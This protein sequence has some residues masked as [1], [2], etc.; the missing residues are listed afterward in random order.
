[1]V[2]SLF[3]S[4]FVTGSVVAAVVA[5]CMLLCG[6]AVATAAGTSTAPTVTVGQG[7]NAAK[8]PGAQVFGDTP[9]STPESV[10]FI[11]REQNLGQLEASV[12]QGFGPYLSVAQFARTYGQTSENVA[13][14]EAYLSQFGIKTQ[15]YRDNVDVVATGTAGEFDRALGVTQHQYRVP[16]LPGAGGAPA[17][18]AQT[19]HGAAQAPKLPPSIAHYVLAVLGLS[20][21]APFVSHIAH[22]DTK[23]TH[24]RAGDSNSCVALTGTTVDCN[25]ASD[26][27]ARYGLGPVY[28]HGAQGQ[29]QTLAIV[30]LA[31]LDPGAAPHYW[32]SILG[33][34]PSGRTLKVQNIDG[35]PGAAS[36]DSGSGE[37][38]LDVE[39]SGGVAPGAN[40]VVYQ[41]ANT[42]P[43]F[44]DAFFTAASQNSASSVSTS[45]GESET[46]VETAI[47][48]GTET[49]AYLQAFDEAF[50]EFAAQGQSG[51]IASG[52][53]GAYDAF[54]D[55]GTTDLSV[56]TN[57]D[58]P[59]IT[60]AGGTTL[61]FSATLTGP[62]GSATVRVPAQRIWGWD[63]LWP[64]IAKVTPE[65]LATAAE[66]PNNVLGSGGGFSRTEPEPS[67]QRGVPGTSSFSAV[68]Y[69]TPTGY[70][71]V[72]GITLPTTWRFDPRPP[73][74]R[75][76]GSGRELPDLATNGDPNTG[77]LLYEPSF[78][79]V[80]QPVLQGGWGGTSFVA[81][82]LNGSAAV[83]DSYLGRR[84]GLWNPTIYGFATRSQSPFTPLDQPGTS[85]DNLFF[86]GTPG[87][88]YNQGAGLGYPDL[89]KL[90]ND[91]AS[92]G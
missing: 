81:P 27:A 36:D 53:A 56:D 69:L 35:G 82:Q 58:S 88:V 71:D 25:T 13:S 74:I 26:F 4:R 46:Y 12:E 44:A 9:A 87:T 47:A 6:S 33:L 79:G 72:D 52:D 22:A 62:G 90:A 2:S 92:A 78:A 48:S 64:A 76:S 34:T 59:F 57:S 67:Y 1:M 45:W 77:Y 14:L 50:L 42:D 20:N 51:F 73:V 86:S 28:R 66:D 43:G 60:A 37:T 23:L 55:Q 17:T 15:A 83:I 54:S 16:R 8:L 61:P 49:P 31:A 32:K 30:T 65:P 3:R 21:Y 18:P 38:D 39:Q 89:S 5:A 63:Y 40:V 85:N 70:Q 91:F 41:A 29:G 11:L 84:V 75:G 7:I 68:P 24:P 19:V 10:S 80:G